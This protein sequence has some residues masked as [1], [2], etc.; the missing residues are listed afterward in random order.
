MKDDYF[1]HVE[2]VVDAESPMPHRARGL[3]RSNA[4]RDKGGKEILAAPF[5]LAWKGM[6][7]ALF[8]EQKVPYRKL[9]SFVQKYLRLLFDTSEAT[10]L[11]ALISGDVPF[12]VAWLMRLDQIDVAMIDASYDLA[13]R[14]ALIRFR[15]AV[16]GYREVAEKRLK[17]LGGRWPAVPKREI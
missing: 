3:S 1:A 15:A 16:D 6:R 8:I 4:V 17:K 5:M 9:P 11:R 13:D 10:A 2:R 14:S 12:F 7:E